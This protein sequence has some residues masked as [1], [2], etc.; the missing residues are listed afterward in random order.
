M[1]SF[2]DPPSCDGA[3]GREDDDDNAHLAEGCSDTTE[4]LQL[5]PMNHRCFNSD[6]VKPSNAVISVTAEIELAIAHT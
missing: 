2:A 6:F 3:A 1:S 4:Q 5:E